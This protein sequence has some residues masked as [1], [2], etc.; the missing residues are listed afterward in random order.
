MNLEDIPSLYRNEY[1][2]ECPLCTTTCTVL[3]QPAPGEYDTKI[4]VQ[5]QCGEYLEF[6][7]PVN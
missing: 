4:Y 7:L 3:T 2:E 6:E 5:C 1:S